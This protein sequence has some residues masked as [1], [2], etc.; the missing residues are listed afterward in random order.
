MLPGG[1]AEGV[2]VDGDLDVSV[3]VDELEELPSR[4]NKWYKRGI[5]QSPRAALA[6]LRAGA[7]AGGKEKG[8]RAN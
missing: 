3:F 2:P 6:Q 5:P 1:R 8:K 7:E 4:R